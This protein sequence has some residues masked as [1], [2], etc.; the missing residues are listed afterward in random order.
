MTSILVV[1][2]NQKNMELVVYLLE[3]N[4]MKVRQAFDRPEVLDIFKNNYFDQI[5]RDIKLSGMCG[6]EVLRNI[7]ED[8][9]HRHTPIVALTAHA[10]QGDE[11][12]FMDVDCLGYISKP[13]DVSNFLGT[14][15]SFVGKGV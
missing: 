6:I 9:K 12:K 13:I 15:Q 8:K 11:Q 4:E 10:M 1:E 7:K 3:S 2:N 14:I 5:L